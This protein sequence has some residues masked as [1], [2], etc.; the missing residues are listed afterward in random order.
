MTQAFEIIVQLVAESFLSVC[1]TSA[2]DALIE[3]KV[4]SQK[5]MQK[6]KNQYVSVIIMDCAWLLW[7]FEKYHIFIKI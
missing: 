2:G 5:I 6:K 7:N 1:S 4:H 3:T